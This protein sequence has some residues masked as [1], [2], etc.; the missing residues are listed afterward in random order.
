MVGDGGKEVG[1]EASKYSRGS[2]IAGIRGGWCF[3]LLVF[4]GGFFYV[5]WLGN[6][7]CMGEG[8]P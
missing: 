8:T 2:T 7:L 6:L 4:F 5:A 3:L 1:A